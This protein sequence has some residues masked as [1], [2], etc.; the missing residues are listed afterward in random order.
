VTDR[1]G[2][3]ALVLA[4]GSLYWILPGLPFAQLDD[5]GQWGVIG[6]FLTLLTLL[7]ARFRWLRHRRLRLWLVAFLCAMPVV[8]VAYWLRY[9]G[10]R[11][12]LWIELGGLVVFWAIAWAAAT[13]S[14]W[15]LVAGIGGHAIWDYGHWGRVE[16]VTDWYAL[17][18]FVVDIALAVYVAGQIPSWLESR[19][20]VYRR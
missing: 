3:L 15:L 14:P 2:I 8:Y 16:F 4:T 12:W 9:A 7:R 11:E 13:I 1:L 17:A 10:P 5:P 6:Y 19:P 20:L 18:C